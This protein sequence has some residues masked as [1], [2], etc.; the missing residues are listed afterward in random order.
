MEHHDIAYHGRRLHEHD[1][2][3]RGDRNEAKIEFVAPGEH[4]IICSLYFKRFPWAE[5]C[6]CQFL[7]SGGVIY[8]LRAA[9]A[10]LTI[11]QL[12]YPSP[13]SAQHFN[14]KHSTTN[15]ITAMTQGVIH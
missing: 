11:W 7:F 9:L 3:Y 13:V 6:F 1:N 2:G 10:I 12:G 8:V 15:Y 5:A 14:W 4:N